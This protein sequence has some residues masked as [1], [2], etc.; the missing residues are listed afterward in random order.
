MLKRLGKDVLRFFSHQLSRTQLAYLDLDLLWLYVQSCHRWVGVVISW[1]IGLVDV[2]F[3]CLIILYPIYNFR[4]LNFQVF[5]IV[6]L[7]TIKKLF[8]IHFSSRLILI[9]QPNHPLLRLALPTSFTNHYRGVL[10]I[11]SLDLLQLLLIIA[12]KYS[13]PRF[14]LPNLTN[15]LKQI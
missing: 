13:H 7:I 4:F 10:H 12:N 9:I 6:L 11:F 1:I 5:H 8:K 14:N 2:I 3:P 15:Q